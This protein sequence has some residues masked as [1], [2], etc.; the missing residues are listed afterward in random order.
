MNPEN[1]Q[2]STHFAPFPARFPRF[3]AQFTESGRIFPIPGLQKVGRNR[4]ASRSFS[5]SRI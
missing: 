5:W 2:L 3:R 1:A 4:P